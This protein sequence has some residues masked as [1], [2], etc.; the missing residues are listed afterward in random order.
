VSEH[1]DP[2]IEYQ[3]TGPQ[4]TIEQIKASEANEQARL[5]ELTRQEREQ[6]ERARAERARAEKPPEPEP[7]A[8]WRRSR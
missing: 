1:V 4:P 5:D 6:V 7:P 3:L 2:I 8:W